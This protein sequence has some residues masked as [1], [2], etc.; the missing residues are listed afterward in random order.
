[1]DMCLAGGGREQDLVS[2]QHYSKVM[3]LNTV[4]AEPWHD[5]AQTED[6]NGQAYRDAA[7]LEEFGYSKAQ[8]A[9]I[10]SKFDIVV[11]NQY[12][13][14]IAQSMHADLTLDLN[15][16]V[17]Q[18]NCILENFEDGL[19]T[20]ERFKRQRRAFY[21]YWRGGPVICS[22]ADHRRMLDFTLRFEHAFLD[23][24][25]YASQAIYMNKDGRGNGYVG[26]IVVGF[27]IFCLV[28]SMREAGKRVG[29]CRL[30]TDA[31]AVFGN[32]RA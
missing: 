5:T 26:E 6:A 20:A 17:S 14:N 1:M 9:D 32:T 10:L 19:F 27:A 11:G 24:K 3:D 16:V 23:S 31:D 18:F 7:S 25:P 8:L 12:P 30:L 4:R 28:E 15:D 29:F 21:Q 2:F 22:L 13:C